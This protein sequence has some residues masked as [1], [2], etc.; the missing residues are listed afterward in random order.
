MTDGVTI[1]GEFQ[2]SGEKTSIQVDVI[3]TT[4]MYSIQIETSVDGVTY[5]K[6][7]EYGCVKSGSGT[8]F[9]P[10]DNATINDYIRVNIIPSATEGSVTVQVQN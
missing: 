5:A 4:E 2:L 6:N 10:L 8:T 7:S 1:S 9:I 3:D